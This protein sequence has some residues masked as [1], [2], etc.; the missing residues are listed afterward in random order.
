[1]QSHEF[2]NTEGDSKRVSQ[3]KT[4]HMMDNIDKDLLGLST[5]P[6]QSVNS[7]QSNAKNNASNALNLSVSQP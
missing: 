6:I 1:M 7:R 4:I 5:N 3:G 2:P